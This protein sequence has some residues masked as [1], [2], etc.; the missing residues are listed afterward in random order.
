MIVSKNSIE[1][2]L[3]LFFLG[4][5]SARIILRDTSEYILRALVSFA[6]ERMGSKPAT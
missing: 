2:L 5:K 6:R 4:Y 1:K 3:K